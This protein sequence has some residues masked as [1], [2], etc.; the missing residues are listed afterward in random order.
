LKTVVWAAFFGSQTSY[1]A[2]SLSD[3]IRQLFISLLPAV[4]SSRATGVVTWVFETHYITMNSLSNAIYS[5][6]TS[7]SDRIRQLLISLLPAVTSSRATGVV[8]W[9]FETHYI[10]MN[11][12]SNAIYSLEKA[13]LSPSW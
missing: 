8:T 1:Y 12:L 6:L 5:D 3:R 2:T 13:N 4:T 11:S 9:V 10:T 7:L